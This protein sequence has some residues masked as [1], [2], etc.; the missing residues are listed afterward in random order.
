VRLVAIT[1]LY[2]P[3]EPAAYSRPCLEL[4][5]SVGIGAE[6]GGSE[7][8][9]QW[10]LFW[11]S[12]PRLDLFL[13]DATTW[14]TAPSIDPKLLVACYQAVKQ[15]LEGSV[16]SDLLIELTPHNFVKRVKSCRHDHLAP[17]RLLGLRW[18]ETIEARA[19]LFRGI[20]AEAGKVTYASFGRKLCD[21]KKE[22]PPTTQATIMTLALRKI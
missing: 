19:K 1:Q 13:S 20:T 11:L 12:E 21:Q 5:G 7:V 16:I 18:I 6:M 22:T 9:A 15:H 2:S 8:R 3:R 14:Q 17:Y 4:G 10:N